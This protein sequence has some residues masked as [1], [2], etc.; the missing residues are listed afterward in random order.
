MLKR[1]IIILFSIKHFCCQTLP[2]ISNRVRIGKR[3]QRGRHQMNIRIGICDDEKLIAEKLRRIVSECLS[4]L[5]HDAEIFIFLSGKSLLKKI[6]E[7]EVVFLDIKM[8]GLDGYETGK[9]IRKLNPDCRIIMETGEFDRFE[10]AFEIGAIRY[11]RKPF[12]KEKIK[13]AL[14]KVF[15]GFVG[16]EKIEVYRE[17]NRYEFEQRRIKYIRAYNGYTEYYIGKDVFRNELSLNEVELQLDNRL[18]YKVSRQ[19]VINMEEVERKK[20]GRIYIDE[21]EIHISRRRKGEF[22]KA[23]MDYIFRR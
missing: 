19:Y 4:E 21:N 12:D 9:Y 8:K 16:M 7:L 11:I 23:Y 3:L 1:V 2:N 10:K 5:G 22:E 20:D 18:F 14:N 15:G 13:E 17:R 6:T